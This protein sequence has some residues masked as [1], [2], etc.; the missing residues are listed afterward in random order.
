MIVEG[1]DFCIAGE[2]SNPK[3]I[4]FLC[5]ALDPG[6]LRYFGYGGAVRG[7][8]S[9]VVLFLLHQLSLKFPG[10]KWVVVRASLPDL[11]KTTIPSFN[12]LIKTQL[13]GK[14]N[15]SVPITFHYNNG[16]EIIFVPESISID[17]DLNSFLGFECSG[18]FLEQLEEL[19]KKM[20]DMALQRSGSLYINPM[21]PAYVFTTF[22][23]NQGFSKE[24]FYE[25]YINGTIQPPY[26][27][28]PALPKDN[29]HVTQDQWNAWS[30]MAERYQLQF[31]EGDWSDFVDANTLWAFAFN[32]KKH[33]ARPELN[34][35]HTVY[36]SFDFNKNP[37]CCSVIQHYDKKLR[38]LETIKLP[39]S[40]IYALCQH[41]IVNYP[42]LMFMVTGDASGKNT[43]AMVKDN[44]NYYRIIKEQLNLGMQQIV[45]PTVNPRL[46]DNQVLVNS[47]LARYE[48]EVHEERAKP[49]I[50]D[51][52]NVKMLPDGTIEK[53]DRTDPA[54]QADALD[55]FRYFCNT[56]MGWFIRK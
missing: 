21:P 14:W 13:Y 10:S 49:L 23:P 8:K 53:G 55:T 50:Y 41:I 25:P 11:K 22:N 44:L 29:P 45:V 35:E 28:M 34:P 2:K 43:S 56:F 39:N 15:Y 46:E 17:P 52:Q 37:I 54:K 19:S 30:N 4:E 42:D 6:P 36:L 31:I 16:S 38:V 20:W 26:F 33:V 27:Y 12:K 5:T 24:L 18:F 7:G 3:Q 32:R 9:Y 48:V 47:I 51:F 1:T 40:D